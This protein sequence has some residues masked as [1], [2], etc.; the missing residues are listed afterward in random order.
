M[1]SLPKD[2]RFKDETLKSDPEIHS[3]RVQGTQRWCNQDV[4]IYLQSE[5]GVRQN[6]WT[7]PKLGKQEISLLD[8]MSEAEIN[9]LIKTQSVPD[10]WK[11]AVFGSAPGVSYEQLCPTCHYAN[12]MW[13]AYKKLRIS[14]YWLHH[15]GTVKEDP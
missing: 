13:E 3:I 2:P 6:V 15:E 5:D 11:Q 7:V 10:G 8:V 4:G 14:Y 1:A 9:E 12:Q